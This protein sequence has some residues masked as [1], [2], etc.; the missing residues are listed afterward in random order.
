MASTLDVEEV[1]PRHHL[2]KLGDEDADQA[3]VEYDVPAEVIRDG[4]SEKGEDTDLPRA[5][6][7]EL[8]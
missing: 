5:V 2:A 6:T 8:R 1:A 7:R 3:V 4:P